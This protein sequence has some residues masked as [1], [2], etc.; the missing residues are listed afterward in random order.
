MKSTNPTIAV[1]G[2]GNVGAHIV[3]ASLLK[4]ISAN[5]L[6]IDMNEKFENAQVLDLRDVQMFSPDAS[7]AGADIGKGKVQQADIIV[8]TAGAK[9]NP[10]ESRCELLSK[11]IQILQSIKKGIGDINPKALIVMV[12]N[13]VDV[14]TQLAVDIFKLPKTQVFGTGTLLD[15]ARLR[16]RLADKFDRNIADVDGY[17]LGEHGDS[18]FI[19]W[20]H[21][22]KAK[23]I[24]TKEKAEIERSVMMQA[25]EIIEGK[26]STYF[27]I[28]AAT[29]EL[30]KN[31]VSD[32]KKIL[33]LSCCLTG[34]YGLNG[35][36]L[37]IPAKIGRNGIEKIYELDLTKDEQEKLE[38]SAQKLKKL[39]NQCEV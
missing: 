1:I 14:L 15:S 16:W 28:G 34:E 36:A 37:G 11:N 31:I 20:S 24:N 4:N 21:V 32:S 27:G 12:T 10:G 25:Y 26:G 13:P 19:A 35:V 9:Q 8:I 18:E 39:F 6:L 22:S 29:A 7:I 5:F 30:L 3:S 2:A 38:L 23:E 17:V 33:P